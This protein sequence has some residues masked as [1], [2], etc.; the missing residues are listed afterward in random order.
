MNARRSLYL[1]AGVLSA[2]LM[3]LPAFA[4][5]TVGA[6]WRWLTFIVFAAIIGVTMFVTYLAAKRVKSAS[7]F[8]TAGG[9]VSG[10]QNGWA[11]DKLGVERRHVDA[12]VEAFHFLQVL[13]LRTQE[14]GAAAAVNRIDPYALNEVDQRMLKEAFRQARKLQQ[15]LKET[16]SFAL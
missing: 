7:D 8:Y 2:P 5:G 15:R 6:E 11:G 9:G 10:L 14:R 16:Y 13:R 1:A 4:Q 3:A 12:T